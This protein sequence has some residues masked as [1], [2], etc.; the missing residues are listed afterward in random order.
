MKG[1]KAA[2]AAVGCLI[3]LFSI[4]IVS[5]NSSADPVFDEDKG[6]F[7]SMAVT[8]W[9]NPSQGSDPADSVTWDFGDGTAPVT[10]SPYESVRHVYAA[11]GVYYISQTATNMIGSNT[12]VYKINILGYPTVTYV[13]GHEI[14]DTVIQQTSYNVTAGSVAIPDVEGF[15][16]DGW[17]TDSGLTAKYTF[18][19]ITQPTTLYAKWI[20]DSA[21][22]VVVDDPE[23][24]DDVKKLSN[25]QIAELAVG[26]FGAAFALIGLFL[27][28]FDVIVVGIIAAAAGGLLFFGVI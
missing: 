25:L 1:I 14:N 3:I 11:T 17:Y 24:P 2:L 5:D 13:F 21:P 28:R 10:V 16:F 9:Y 27:R 6:S 12:A 7:W 26:A 20:D 19:G 4:A 8:V 15:T 18:Q 22:P 23:Q